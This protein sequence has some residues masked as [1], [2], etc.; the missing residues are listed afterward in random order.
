MATIVIEDGSQVAGANSYV[1]E[2]ELT[3]YATDRGL[4]LTG[5]PA[6]LLI[7]AMDYIEEQDFKGFKTSKEQPLQ[8]P[9]YGV[10]IDGYD[11]ASDVIPQLLKDCQMEAALA[12]DAGN[13]PLSSVG[14]EVKRQKL[15]GLE[16][17]YMDGARFDTYNRALETKLQR[18]LKVGGSGLSTIAIRG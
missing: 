15:E 4:T 17:E 14:R 13:N 5:T 2:A 18:L 8:W 3:T 12:T 7:Q 9:R 1:T 10:W 16:V 6:V 11:I